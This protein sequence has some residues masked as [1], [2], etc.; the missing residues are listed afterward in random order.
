M[1]SFEQQRS[2]PSWR[3]GAK[4]P[5]VGVGYPSWTAAV[6]P[7]REPRLNKSAGW[8]LGGSRWRIGGRLVDSRNPPSSMPASHRRVG[9]LPHG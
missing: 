2:V 7:N 8:Q 1:A 5:A 9:D 4:L 3:L 6:T